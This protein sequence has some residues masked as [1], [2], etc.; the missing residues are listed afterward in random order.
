VTQDKSIVGD[1]I[2]FRGLVYAPLNENGVVYLFGKVTEDLHMYVEEIKPGF[3]DCIARRFT[4]KGWE[5]IRVE[6]EFRS[7]HFKQ[8][9]HD[10]EACDVVICWEHDWEDCPI[11]VI[12]LRTAIG[13]MENFP[14][15]RPG[16]TYAEADAEK[17]FDALFARAETQESARGW[18][19]KIKTALHEHDEEIWFNIG[20]RFVGFYSPEKAFASF[21]PTKTGLRFEC[22]TRGTPMDG[23]RVSNKKYSPRWGRFTV[24]GEGQVEFAVKALT[25][26]QAR[27]KA[28]IRVGEQTN[29]FSGGVGHADRSPS[30]E[31]DESSRSAA[32]P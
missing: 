12:E 4:G 23:V 2:N 31:T 10:P 32:R 25:E 20:K 3:P 28:A 29:Y 22:F 15:K 9:G 17:T 7:S 5:R 14:I 6:F 8:H 1:L 13:D 16:K 26:S 30:P 19:E 21:Q 18:W 24:K 11:E 27:L